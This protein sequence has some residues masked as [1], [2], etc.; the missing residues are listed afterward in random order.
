MSSIEKKSLRRVCLCMIVKNESKN[1]IKCLNSCVRYIDGWCIFDTGSTDGTQEIITKYFRDYSLQGELHQS[2]WKDF[3]TNRNEYLNSDYVKNFDYILVLDGDEELI[4]E[5]GCDDWK[6][7]NEVSDLNLIKVL[8]PT[9][10]HSFYPC[11]IGTNN[12]AYYEGVTHENLITKIDPP[13]FNKISIRHHSQNEE[14]EEAKQKKLL[15]DVR[16]LE[17]ELFENKQISPRLRFQYNYYLCLSYDALGNVENFNRWYRIFDFAYDREEIEFDKQ[18][19]WFLKYRYALSE[20]R[21]TIADDTFPKDNGWTKLMWEAYHY[22]ESR[23]EP[24]GCLMSYYAQIGDYDN[25]KA[26]GYFA[27]KTKLTSEDTIHINEFEHN[28]IIPTLYE[29][30]KSKIDS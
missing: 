12:E 28:H 20:M 21:K 8:E 29:M 4:V 19:I 22:R 7:S 9:G 23:V 1:I 3:A 11:L 25:A 30:V 2:E 13:I 17:K 15:R 18:Y 24:L 5:S 26:I 27:M 16:L 6:N 10:V 14:S